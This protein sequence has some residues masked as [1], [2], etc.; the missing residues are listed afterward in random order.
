M[1]I[2]TVHVYH[3]LQGC[4]TNVQ[5]ITKI[6]ASTV[7]QTSTATT[8]VTASAAATTTATQ[9]VTQVRTRTREGER[10]RVTRG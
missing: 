9:T 5:H 8:T 1:G 10:G 6:L 2:G 3:N 4:G 7:T